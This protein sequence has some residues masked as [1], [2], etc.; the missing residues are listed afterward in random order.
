MIY[1]TFAFC[2]LSF[3]TLTAIGCGGATTPTATNTTIANA[4]SATTAIVTNAG[5]NPIGGGSGGGA[6][7]PAPA[8]NSAVPGIPNAPANM[9][10]P[11]E[12]MTRTAKPQL[13]TRAAPDNSDIS[14]TLGEN[15][16]ETRTFKNN[17]QIAKIERITEAANN[18]KKTVKVYLRN[19]QVRE[20]PDGKVADAMAE[21]AANIL[22]A[23]AESGVATQPT[24][25]AAPNQSPNA[26][27]APAK[28]KKK[29]PFAKQ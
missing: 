3:L 24:E 23:V 1:K 18:G 9:V 12:D 14:T 29:P 19:G 16:V 8:T 22:K 5:A 17:A 7:Q 11:K 25:T 28:T 27:A 4:N 2:S 6:A 10:V 15:L 20:L 21:T 13:V 26:E